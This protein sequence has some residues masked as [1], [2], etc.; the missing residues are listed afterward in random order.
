MDIS[1]A[2]IKE[3]REKTGAGISDVKKAL[4]SGGGDMAKA[5]AF[6]ERKLGSSAVKKA[7]RETKTGIIEAYVHSN[8]RIGVL[9][10]L[11]CETDFVGRN[12]AFKE[13]AHDIAMHIAAMS[14]FYLSINSV[15]AE[16]WQKEKD[17]IYSEVK[18]LG[19]P[20]HML[21]EI[22]EGKLK[23]YFGEVSLLEQSF[24]K[25]Q[26]KTV[27]TIISEAVGKFGENIKVGRFV[28]LE[29]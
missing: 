7:S 29:I 5:V 23:S 20:G 9:V 11:F 26:N 12:P 22:T 8:F 13:L 27:E 6:I 28:R 25:D 24:V 21:E 19:K 16:V 1:T 10:E 17:R 2:Q 15:S 4:E 14:P 3:L 18:K